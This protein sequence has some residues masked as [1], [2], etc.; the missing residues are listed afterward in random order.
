M[1]Q[2]ELAARLGISDRQV[3]NLAKAGMPTH[4]EEAARAW[5]TR[6][7]DATQ[8]RETR[9]DGNP[10]PAPWTAERQG[11]SAPPQM[12]FGFPGRARV[13]TSAPSDDDSLQ[14]DLETTD[15]DE[16]FRSAR[17][18]KEKNLALQAKAEYEEFIAQL[19]KR[20]DVER[21]VSAIM[22]QMRDGLINVSRRLAPELAALTDATE[23]EQ[24]IDREHRALLD[25]LARN[26]SERFR[27]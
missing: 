15:A 12:D 17:A 25:T 8:R 22:R 19:V 4:S 26:F 13:Q 20:E 7:L 1:K 18:I 24:A 6:H 5:R 16:L 21:G 2:V 3:R 11:E 27:L 10:G 23:C 14:I 9:I